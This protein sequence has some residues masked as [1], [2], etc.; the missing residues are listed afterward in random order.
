MGK[1]CDLICLLCYTR[2]AFHTTE[3]NKKNKVL[4]STPLV[5]S[6]QSEFLTVLLMVLQV[7][8]NWNKMSELSQAK[9]L[10][11]SW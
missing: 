7:K 10:Y 3:L 6:H 11:N 5:K 8:D 2:I 1:I 4:Q 9:K